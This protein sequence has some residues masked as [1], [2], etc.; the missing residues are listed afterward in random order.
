MK[1]LILVSLLLASS[2][3]AMAVNWIDTGVINQV[4]GSRSFVDVDSVKVYNFGET[5]QKYITFW[6][7]KIYPNTQI[8]NGKYYID[9]TKFMYFDCQNKKFNFDFLGHYDANGNLNHQERAFVDT[10]SSNT[11]YN[12]PPNSVGDLEINQVCNYFKEKGIL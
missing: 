10:S 8:W 3:M 9:I 5:K 7:K 4:N 12:S 2:Q 11:W 6:H 1:K